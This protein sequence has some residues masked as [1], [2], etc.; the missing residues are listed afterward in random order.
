MRE[1]GVTVCAIGRDLENLRVAVEECRRC[2]RLVDHRQRVA[3]RRVRRFR[4]QEYWGR[5]VAGFGDRAARLLIVGLAP[6]AHGGNRTGR[7]FTGDRSGDFLFAALYRAGFA[8]Q[9][10]STHRDD[11]LQLNDCYLT[12]AVRCA[13]PENKPT[14]AEFDRCRPFLA[15]ELRLLPNVRVVVALGRIAF[16]A[17]LTVW[18]PSARALPTSRPR[19]S[20]A[21]EVKLPG[22]VTL[23]ASYHPSQRNTQTGLLTASMFARI[24]DRARRLIG[25]ATR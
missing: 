18:V 24:F 16:D 13:P 6:A 14:P 8:N 22:A 21:A 17:F 20:H 15:E 19:F 7:M 5:P 2:P 10:Q 25:R 9:S 23:L 4:D 11:G 1:C 12:A 3:E